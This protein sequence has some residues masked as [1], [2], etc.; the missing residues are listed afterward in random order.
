MNDQLELNF[1][2]QAEKS[3]SEEGRPYRSP[4][5]TRQPVPGC[6]RCEG[7]PGENG[8]CWDHQLDD[9]RARERKEPRVSREEIEQ[10][11]GILETMKRELLEAAAAGRPMPWR[12]SEDMTFS[13]RQA[14][15]YRL[16]RAMR[17]T[18]CCIVAATEPEKPKRRGR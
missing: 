17:E 7:E 3:I 9:I 8:L 11:R 6:P 15:R 13:E 2:A 5:L 1:D 10:D 12:E 14:F 4:S 16:H 18:G